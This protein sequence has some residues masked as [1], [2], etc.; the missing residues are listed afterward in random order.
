VSAKLVQTL[1]KVDTFIGTPCW[2]SPEV[3]MKSEYNAKT[4][5]WS[6]GITVIEM[7][8]GEP[9]YNVKGKLT[10]MAIVN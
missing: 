5:I 2:M 1:A 8:E 9:P 3:L 4:D 6:F 10:P 7:A